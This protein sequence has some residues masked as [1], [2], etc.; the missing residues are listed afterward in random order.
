VEGQGGVSGGLTDF[1]PPPQG[2]FSLDHDQRHTLSAGGV[3]DLWR[4]S[5]AAADFQYG[6][7]FLNG[8]GPGH[9]PS[10]RTLNLALGKSFGEKWS[11]RLAATNLTN[12]RY[13]IDLSNTFGGSHFAD[14]RKLSL[15]V[16]YRFGY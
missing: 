15:Q 7:G 9:L 11:L 1:T 2:F 10:Y 5:W 3:A 8:N 13:Q 12:K 4:Q 16:R 6:S 14:P